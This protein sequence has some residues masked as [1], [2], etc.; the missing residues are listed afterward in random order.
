[1]QKSYLPRISVNI[2]ILPDTNPQVVLESL[3]RVDYPKQLIEILIIEGRH[4]AKQRNIG[5]KNSKG[6]ILYLLDN[7]SQVNPKAF[8]LIAKAFTNPNI[9]AVGGP[10]LF[11]YKDGNFVSQLIGYTLETYFGAMRM[12]FRYSRQKTKV[13]KANEY[14]LIGANLALRKTAVLKVGGFDETIV[15]NE[16]TELLRRLK[17]KGY[18]LEYNQSM[19]IYR[20]HRGT[21]YQ[22]IKQ[23]SHYGS[24]RMKQIKKEFI[25]QDFLLMS[26]IAFIL[27][28]FS[29][30]IIHPF[31]Y[32]TPLFLYLVLGIATSVKAAIKYKKIILVLCMPLLFPLIHFSYA[33]GLL[34]EFFSI[35]GKINTKGKIRINY[36]KQFP[37]QE[38]YT[39]AEEMV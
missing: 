26:P 35:P 37:L 13:T 1:M 23:F 14:Q 38:A 36:I 5:I 16:E 20:Y 7:D 9:A 21:V 6:K 3:R 24:G 25:P 18:E 39:F 12:R 4:I 31:W 30:I 27:Y 34:H 11:S 8:K 2:P 17:T 28:I 32:L 19:F 33:A 22:L 29:L 15:P 10:S